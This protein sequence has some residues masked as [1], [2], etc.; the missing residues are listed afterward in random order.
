MGNARASMLFSDPPYNL[1]IK[2]IVGRGSIKHREFLSGSGEMSDAQFDAFS[3]KWMSSAARFCAEGSL[4]Y[5]C[6][7]W[8]HLTQVQLVGNEI[9]TE[10]KNYL[11]SGSKTTRARARSTDR[12][13]SSSYCSRMAPAT[14]RTTSNLVG[15][16]VIALTCG[17][18]P[19]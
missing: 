8:R 5:I 19:V 13:T 6:M 11:S 17:P 15:T 18:I 2:A 10:L 12:S 9:F 3:R 7:D 16:A 14:I 4:A 1:R